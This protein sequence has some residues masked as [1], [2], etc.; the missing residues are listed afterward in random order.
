MT[1]SEP[2]SPNERDSSILT[3]VLQRVGDLN[4][5][6][7]VRSSTQDGSAQSG[8][9]YKALSETITFKPFERRKTVGISVLF[10]LEKELGETF[11]VVLSLLPH[12]MNVQ[13]G[14]KQRVSVTI[15]NFAPSGVS[16]V[17]KPK[18]LSLLEYGKPLDGNSDVI[19][20]YP[21]ICVSVS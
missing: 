13:L 4:M 16:F 1:V 2:F 17:L 18:V 7:S 15:A 11:S 5:T 12:S 20:G 9:D 6:S 14:N 21:V 8:Q 19:S 10:D 3:L